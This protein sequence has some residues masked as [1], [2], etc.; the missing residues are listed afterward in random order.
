MDNRDRPSPLWFAPRS[1]I[2]SSS[3]S[4]QTPLSSGPST[5]ALLSRVTEDEEEEEDDNS[6]RHTKSTPSLT[7]KRQKITAFCA[8]PPKPAQVP[9][10]GIVYPHIKV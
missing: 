9:R 4:T 10:C 5:G 8:R 2:G 1:T 6:R 3:T 7:F